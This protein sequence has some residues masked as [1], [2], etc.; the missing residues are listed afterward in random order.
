MAKW[1]NRLVPDETVAFLK[2]FEGYR[3]APYD[4]GAGYWTI[5]YGSTRDINGKKVTPSTP[6][7]THE[8][9]EAMLKR[10]L[11]Y[12]VEIVRASVLLPL[13]EHQA[14]ALISLAYNLGGLKVK[15]KTLLSKVNGGEW[16]AAAEAFKLYQNSGGRPFLGLRR[17][18]WAEAAMFLTGMSGEE[19]YKRG[20]SEINTLFDWPDFVK[21]NIINLNDV[22]K[23]KANRSG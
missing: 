2:R 3:S 8:E 23:G 20:W 19:A 22:R 6:P 15:A 17:R 21:P 12:A 5:G 7:V 9:A 13:E 11:L 16:A 10:D 18:R 1:N 4:D 14:A